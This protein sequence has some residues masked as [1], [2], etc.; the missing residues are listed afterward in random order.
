MQVTDCR[1]FSLSVTDSSLQ[2]QNGGSIKSQIK[3]S[4]VEG[5]DF[6]AILSLCKNISVPVMQ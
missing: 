2:T 6:I 4:Q 3:N 5:Y 1:N